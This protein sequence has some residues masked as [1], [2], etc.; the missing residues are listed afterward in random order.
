MT[1]NAKQCFIKD[2]I[3][4]YSTNVIKAGEVCTIE[5]AKQ[6]GIF[7]KNDYFNRLI[8]KDETIDTLADNKEGTAFSLC[9]VNDGIAYQNCALSTKNPWKT[10]N[11]T[12]TYC[13]LPV[14][15]TLPDALV[16]NTETKKIDKP[17][18]IPKF[19][20]IKDFCQEKWY[21]WFSIPDYHFG[22]KY[23]LIDAEPTESA[24]PTE[25]TK[26]VKPAKCVKPCDI[27]TMPYMVNGKYDKCILRDKFEYGFY[28]NTFHYLP[29][30]LILLLG[31]T[32]ETLLKKYESILSYT[33]TSTLENITTDFELCDNL[34]NDEGTR[35]NIYDNI[36]GDLRY[37][38]GKLFK[39]PFDDTNILPPSFS[40][41]NISN[42]FMTRDRVIDAYE[43]AEELYRLSSATDTETMKL[44]VEWKKNL[45]DISGFGI[46]DTK[47]YK[48]LLI[49][50]KACNVAFDRTSAYSNDLIFN[51]LNKDN[52]KDDRVYAKIEF[53][54]TDAD[55]VLS[56]RS[57]E[58]LLDV[59]KEQADLIEKEK[60][61]ALALSEKDNVKLNLNKTDANRYETDELLNPKKKASP[62]IDKKKII[63]CAM[64][65]M[66]VL[67]YIMAIFFLVAMMFWTPVSS[68]INEILIGFIYYI[69]IIADMFRG[70]YEPSTVQ[71]KMFQLQ[72]RFID[73]KIF[74]DR[75]TY[76]I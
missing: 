4:D 71:M 28:A 72:R 1:E 69:Y 32:K 26:P 56:K 29:I 34:L 36:K 35:K 53:K 17:M 59:E 12:R 15:V 5:T 25:P 27:G 58:D 55:V 65:Y 52:E 41:Q 48:Q 75:S 31:S 40:V 14:D 64:L 51:T 20:A 16:L 43:I 45:V 46:N 60:A 7:G 73:G 18:P 33:K 24:E 8:P 6:Y 44:Y 67:V 49:L 10:L 23:Q 70:R 9:Q 68:V 38:I 61:G 74:T 2:V 22:N 3:D 30:S 76:L 66:I 11:E 39:V 47:F 13:M 57:G 19:K 37:N 62:G 63:I 42:K 21:D 50:K 54:L